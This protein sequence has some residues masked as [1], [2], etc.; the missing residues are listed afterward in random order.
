MGNNL[1]RIERGYWGKAQPRDQAVSWHPLAYHALDVAAAGKALFAA[2]PKL[3]AALAD[4]AGLEPEEALRASLL[5]LAVHDLGK[6]GDDFQCKAP[7]HWQGRERFQ[8]ERG[9]AEPTKGEGHGKLGAAIWN[10]ATQNPDS[11]DLMPLRNLD[12]WVMAAFAHHGRP[13]DGGHLELSD[14]I[15][16]TA[17]ADAADYLRRVWELFSPLSLNSLRTAGLARAV[18][19]MAGTAIIADWLGS[20]QLWFPYRAPAVSLEAYWNEAQA[21]AAR[22]IRESG[23]EEAAVAGRFGLSQ[24]LANAA[25]TPD[26]EPTPLQDWA[27][28]QTFDAPSLVI[29]ED[30]TGA[31]KTEAALLLAHRMMAGG[32]AEGLYWALPTMATA[33]ALYPRLGDAYKALFEGGDPSLVLAHSARDLNVSFLQSIAPDASARESYGR[34]E[35]AAVGDAPAS[36][37][38][39]AWIADDRRTAFLAQVGVG[40]IDQAL[41]G[42]LPVKHQSIRLAALA[43]RVLVVDEAHA[44][45]EYENRLLEALLE[46]QAAIGGSAI[47]LSA[48]LPLGRRAAY[49][50]AYARGRKERLSPP[51]DPSFPVATTISAGKAWCSPLKS[52]RGTR[53][54][55]PVRR[56]DKEAD[57]DNVLM[58]AIES[59]G[60][61]AWIRNT[62]QD[63]IETAQR[64]RAKTGR[65]VLVFHARFALVDRLSRQN[66]ILNIFGKNSRES[67]RY[68]RLL[69]GTQVL[70]QS[71]DVDWDQIATD[72]SPVDSII[73]RSGR[74][75]RHDRGSRPFPVLNVLGPPPIEDA[76]ENWYARVFPHGQYVYPDHGRLWL[77]QWTLDRF[78]GLP[79]RSR[80][81]RELI[82]AVYGD[83]AADRIP[84]GLQ[85]RADKAVGERISHRS[86]ASLNA[87][88]FGKGLTS[89]AGAWDSDTRTPTRLGEETRTIRLARWDGATL[90]PWAESSDR[91]R[92]WRMSEISVLAHRV[93][94]VVPQDASC[95]AAMEKETSSWAERRFDPP[96]ILPL[97][98]TCSGHWT[99]DVLD[100]A[101]CQIRAK[102]DPEVGLRLG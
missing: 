64:L 92:A 99:C 27:G 57:V 102:Y 68:G 46:F 76:D 95:A 93:A 90:E 101:G 66:E 67:E 59:G 21:Q 30:L 54:D 98:R 36:A 1:G 97:V 86:I 77:T 60:C 73:Q 28:R 12:S 56:L 85:R 42:I 10:A 32:Q 100:S 8:S 96:I 44:F 75:Q 25:D 22:A 63:A 89:A 65:K 2:R 45:A 15:S 50:K 6:F 18:W 55:L 80:S 53:R 41:L 16:R 14:L 29:L 48:T 23:L 61:A 38:C 3:L 11:P 83:A 79:L 49:A 72:L 37:S 35:D 62:V 26:P 33:D 70:E 47:V 81:P 69:I 17:L 82:E 78:C 20:N 13:V 40:T 52:R 34:A 51:N 87:L 9:H 5:T 71:I 58:E 24:A 43:R 88:E 84:S 94:F 74:L 91:R 4:T 31:G 19:T 7:E 39:S